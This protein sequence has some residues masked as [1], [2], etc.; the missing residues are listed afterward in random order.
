MKIN[1]THPEYDKA[2]PLWK[3]CRDCIEGEEAVKAAKSLYL[4]PLPGDPGRYAAYLDRA[5]FFNAV[6]RT[7]AALQGFLFR[8]PAQMS[9][10]RDSV[11]GFSSQGTTS[12]FVRKITMELISVGRAG[13]LVDAPVDGGDPVLSLYFTEDII[14]WRTDSDGNPVLVVLREC[15]LTPKPNDVFVVE[16]RVFYRVL[17]LENGGYVQELYLHDKDEFILQS[18]TAPVRNGS[19]LDHIPFVCINAV[20]GVGF[21][22]VKP[23]LLD[24]VNVNLSHYKSS[25]DLENGRHFVGFPTPWAAG[26][27]LSEGESLEIGAVAWVTDNEN[28]KAGFLEFTGQGLGA[29]ENALSEKEKMMAVLGARLLEGQKKAAEAADTYRLRYAGEQ[30]VLSEIARSG[31]EGV[32]RAFQICAEWRLRP[33]WE[34]YGL[35]LNRDY[36]ATVADPQ[37]VATMFAALQGGGVSYNTWFENLKAWELVPESRTLD[38]E[39]ALIEARRGDEFGA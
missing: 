5:M 18:V 26:F 37:L 39:L 8:K 30:S 34:S 12:D 17:R 21:H 33:D 2:A 38:D 22:V 1:A 6:G 25:A 32:S 24:L 9:P 27:D 10:D 20:G 35:E 31:D 16:E 19:N 7:S 15:R 23:P 29:L 14:N 4:K 28:A 3:K 36:A 13:V 11:G